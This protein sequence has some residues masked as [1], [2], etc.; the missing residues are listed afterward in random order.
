M[1]AANEVAVDAFLQQKTSF[2]RIPELIDRGL[3]S[4]KVQP[5]PEL[6]HIIEADRSTRAFVRT[7]L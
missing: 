3:S 4:H 1:N 6:H 5:S 2:K 7:L